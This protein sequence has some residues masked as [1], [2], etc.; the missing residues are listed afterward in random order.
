[1]ASFDILS[2]FYKIDK[3]DPQAWIAHL[4]M[5]GAAGMIAVTLTYPTDLVRRRMQLV[6]MEGQLAYK[7][8][9]DCTIKIAQNEGFTGLYKGLVPCYVKVIPAMAIMFW[10]N[11]RL[12]LMLAVKE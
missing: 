2:T 1:M 12:K 8:M 5:G 10:C 7:S 4:V 3:N 6:G 9:W 11:E